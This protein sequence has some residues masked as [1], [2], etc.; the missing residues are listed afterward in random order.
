MRRNGEECLKAAVQQWRD[1]EEG[2]H[3]EVQR[4]SGHDGR[5]TWVLLSPSGIPPLSSPI[6]WPQL[7]KESEAELE[8][9]FTNVPL[10]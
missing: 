2:R 3:Q 7:R 5:R 9:F 4:S 6:L 8:V 10:T 1:N